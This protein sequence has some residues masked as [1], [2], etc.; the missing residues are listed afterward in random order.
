[1]GTGKRTGPLLDHIVPAVRVLAFNAVAAAATNKAE[2][3]KLN[4]GVKVYIINPGGT[5][6][7][8]KKLE[9]EKGS[10][11][12]DIMH[13][14]DSSNYLYAKKQGL[15]LPSKHIFRRASL[16]AQKGFHA[17]SPQGS[18]LGTAL[19]TII[20]SFSSNPTSSS[21]MSKCPK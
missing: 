13:S 1:V 4:P 8:I 6:A 7:M 5:E 9:A 18:R 15:L 20:P 16:P 3:K 2:F 11:Q 14:G 12:A 17:I 19:N 21:S 10:P